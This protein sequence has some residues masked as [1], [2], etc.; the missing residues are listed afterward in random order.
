MFFILEP[1]VYYKISKVGYIQVNSILRTK[2]ARTKP[3]SGKVDQFRIFIP[4]KY[5]SRVQELTNPYF[6]PSMLYKIGL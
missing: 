6:T 5:L 4:A 2:E 1:L 3:V